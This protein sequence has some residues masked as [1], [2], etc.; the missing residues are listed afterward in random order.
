MQAFL[1]ALAMEIIKHYG[2]KLTNEAKEAFLKH[3]EYKEA[4]DRSDKYKDEISK[5]GATREERRKAED[6]FMG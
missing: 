6:E 2:P 1:V 4:E 3:L 5:P